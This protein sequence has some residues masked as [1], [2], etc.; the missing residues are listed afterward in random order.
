MRVEIG[1]GSGLLCDVT[2]PCLQLTHTS[3]ELA[4]WYG[5]K[6]VLRLLEEKPESLSVGYVTGVQLG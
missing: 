1:L 3:A 4:D 2:F 5:H 6:H